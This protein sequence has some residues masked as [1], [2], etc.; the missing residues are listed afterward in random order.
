MP[1]RSQALSEA[2]VDALAQAIHEAEVDALAQAIHEAEDDALAQATHQAEDEGAPEACSEDNTQARVE[3]GS[4]PTAREDFRKTLKQL[5]SSPE[6]LL[7]GKA[8]GSI[9][10][11]QRAIIARVG[12]SALAVRLGR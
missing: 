1:G 9:Q 4:K 11:P 7:A 6:R 10:A 3:A 2:E 12:C 5:L 8:R